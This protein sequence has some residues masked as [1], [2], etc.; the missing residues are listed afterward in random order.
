LKYL[1]AIKLIK[2]MTMVKTL[3]EMFQEE[4]EEE[5]EKLIQ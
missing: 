2:R 1:Q 5:V 4:E 3:K